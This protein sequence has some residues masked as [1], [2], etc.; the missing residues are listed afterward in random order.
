MRSQSN[1]NEEKRPKKRGRKQKG[2][3]EQRDT[4]MEKTVFGCLERAHTTDPSVIA[5]TYVDHKGISLPLFCLAKAKKKKGKKKKEKKRKR[6]KGK[7]CVDG[8]FS[9]TVRK[10]LV[11]QIRI[12]FSSIT[13]K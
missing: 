5:R 11:V 10:S 7:R 13:D 12:R 8:Q 2:R 9:H 3:S 4:A 6:K 1:P